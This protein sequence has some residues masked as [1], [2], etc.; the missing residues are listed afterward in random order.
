MEE[1]MSSRLESIVQ[2]GDG[3]LSDEIPV[4]EC[5]ERV[6]FNI[7]HGERWKQALFKHQDRVCH[8]HL[9]SLPVHIASK[10]PS[11]LAV[12]MIQVL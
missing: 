8:K 5:S 2:S 3:R 1:L 6:F 9:G 7:E 4:S 11:W 10:Q 12:V